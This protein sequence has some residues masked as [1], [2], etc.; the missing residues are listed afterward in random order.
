M[1]RRRVTVGVKGGHKE[2]ECFR[3]Q[4]F[5]SLFGAG[6]CIAQPEIAADRSRWSRR[7]DRIWKKIVQSEP[8][9]PKAQLLAPNPD[10]ASTVSGLLL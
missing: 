5:R 4:G 8:K 3:V 7:P 1:S 6:F 9:A 2:L 10:P